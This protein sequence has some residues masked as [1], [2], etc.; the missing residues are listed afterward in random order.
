M[1][2]KQQLVETPTRAASV[3]S[4]NKTPK[5]VVRCELGHRLYIEMFASTPS[6]HAFVD[7]MLDNGGYK[8]HDNKMLVAKGG[9]LKIS[10]EEMED[11]VEYKP[12]TESEH[13]LPEN[14]ARQIDAFLKGHW[15]KHVKEEDEPA[16][17]TISAQKKPKP[18]S[19]TSPRAERAGLVTIQDICSRNSWD[20][21]RVRAI[22]RNAK[23][24]S[25]TSGWAW[26]KDV[27]TQK[28]K[29]LKK[30]IK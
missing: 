16:A 26:P 6:A 7:T 9:V 21:K 10:C 3:S 28:E 18:R 25:P 8:W 15:T 24:E 17:R 22:M 12:K 30:L 19:A 29:E 1:A 14:M 11:I 13:A 5:H 20:P 2:S 23:W 4:P 27:A